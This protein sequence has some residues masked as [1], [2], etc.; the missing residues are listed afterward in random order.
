M[1][2]TFLVLLGA[3]ILLSTPPTLVNSQ[4]TLLGRIN[5]QTREA[6]AA[7]TT[8]PLEGVSITLTNLTLRRAR[9]EQTNRKGIFQFLNLTPGNYRVDIH[10]KGY[11]LG[12]TRRARVIRLRVNEPV[13]VL[14]AY[15]LIRE[16]GE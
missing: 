7:G 16:G 4:G 15:E 3:L 9:V 5:G 10:K 2:P 12:Q 14:P 8:H 1:K 11:Q 6:T 13:R